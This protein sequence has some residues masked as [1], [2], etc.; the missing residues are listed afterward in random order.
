MAYGSQSIVPSL[1]SI[2]GMKRPGVGGLWKGDFNTAS[3]DCKTIFK[4]RRQKIVVVAK[5][6]KTVTSIPSKD[7]DEI[8][9]RQRRS[10]R[11]AAST[12]G[13]TSHTDDVTALRKGRGGTYRADE[14]SRARNVSP[15][16][17]WN[18]AFASSS[19]KTSLKPGNGNVSVPGRP[20]KLLF[21]SVACTSLSCAS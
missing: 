13:R 18:Y 7:D 4:F 12:S 15:D 10:S 3:A 2:D 8:S 20:C 16:A 6:A 11:N 21:F 1:Q 17:L 14:R 9:D 5:L 19:T